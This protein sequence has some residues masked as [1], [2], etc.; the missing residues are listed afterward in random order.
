M[1]RL[2]VV[3]VMQLFL[4]AVVAVAGVLGPQSSGGISTGMIAG[5]AAAGL[6]AAIA[7]AGRM[8]GAW[9]GPA[10]L[11]L[12]ALGLAL[13]GTGVALGNATFA[14]CGVLGLILTGITSVVS[15]QLA[16]VG[17]GTPAPA[18]AR[19][20]ANGRVEEILHQIHENGMLSD[21]AKRVVFRS[22]E[23][24]LLRS[25]IEADIERGD[26]N[27]ALRLC[28]DLADL[29]GYREEA[30]VFRSRINQTRHETY[31]SQI[32]A[33]VDQ[34][35]EFLRQRNWSAAHDVAA[36]IRRLFP[37]AHVLEL[38]DNR[39]NRA[40][41]E[42]R[43]ELEERFRDAAQKEDF[44]LAMERLRELDRYLGPD[45]A[46]RL[47]ELAH[48]VVAKHR[49]N[50]GTQFKMAVN[51]RRW[52]DAARVGDAIVNEFPNTKMAGEVRSMIDV[53]RTRASQAAVTQSN[54]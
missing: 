50:L 9:R 54:V 36:R 3:F 12:G 29:F 4:A 46:S 49:D 51:D 27:A 40:R 35:D 31:E 53:I 1:S 32:Q 20:T 38:V 13:F 15:A 16:E 11:S 42:H 19:T 44:E 33:A 7:I 43:S 48:S 17:G 47:S 25:V 34:L 26:F 22:R 23:L 18:A 52:A 39:I 10:L 28:D 5:L 21:M 14:A 2:N 6:I 41:D 37:E 45:D 30:E 8:I 24:E